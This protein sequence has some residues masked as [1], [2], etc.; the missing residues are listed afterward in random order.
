MIADVSE[1]QFAYNAESCSL[2]KATGPE[3]VRSTFLQNVAD[4]LPVDTASYPK[5]LSLY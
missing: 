3:G 2:R 1:E 5:R 4:Y